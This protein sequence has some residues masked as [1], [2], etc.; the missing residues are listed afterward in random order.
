[1]MLALAAACSGGERSGPEADAGETAAISRYQF[2]AIP[3]DRRAEVEAMVAR[4]RAQLVPIAAGS[5]RMGSEHGERWERP[6]REVTIEA[7]ELATFELRNSDYALYVELSGRADWPG[8]RFRE[9]DD[10]AETSAAY[11]SWDDAQV[12]L[13]WLRSIDDEAWRLPTEAEW[14]YAARAGTATE[15]WWG[16]LFDTARGNGPGRHGPDIWES[17]APVGRFPPNPWGLYDITGNVAEWVQDCWERTYEMA[18]S[19]G[20]ARDDA[21]CDW[22]VIRG[23][24]WLQGNQMHR[25]ASRYYLAPMDATSTQVGLRLAR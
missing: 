12:F 16:D 22:R 10:W 15:Y 11:L 6:V 4:L 2:P 9:R 24:S 7:F 13:A 17:A 18:P 19:D 14:E 20:S 21:G 3:D 1:M 8:L 5:F 25:S 23:G